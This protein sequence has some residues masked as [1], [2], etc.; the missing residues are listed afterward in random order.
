MVLAFVLPLSST[1]GFSIS[2]NKVP[3]SKPAPTAS[4]IPHN[5]P[6]SKTVGII[7]TASATGADVDQEET[8]Y[9]DQSDLEDI[10]KVIW[11]RRLAKGRSGKQEKVTESI[12][13]EDNGDTLE[14]ARSPG[15]CRTADNPG[16]SE[17]SQGCGARNA[18]TI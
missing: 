2:K 6:P 15:K 14:L 8:L 5:G 7:R 1:E 3:E 17:D 9:V 13:D 12:R 10:K 4:P 11:L 18:S 16:Q